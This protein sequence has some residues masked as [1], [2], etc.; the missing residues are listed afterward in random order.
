MAQAIFRSKPFYVQYPTFSTQSQ[1]VAQAIFRAKPFHVQ[2][3]TF[4]TAVTLHTHPPMKT[5][6]TQR[7]ETLAFKLQ[8]AGNKPE[9]YNYKEPSMSGTQHCYRACP[10]CCCC[11]TFVRPAHHLMRSHKWYIQHVFPLIKLNLY[12]KLS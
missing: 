1:F 7:S 3:P 9:T 2:Y 5:E 6:H 8:T 10:C 12:T 4:P 11:S